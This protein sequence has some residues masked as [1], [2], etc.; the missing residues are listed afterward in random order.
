[1]WPEG[2]ELDEWAEKLDRLGIQ[3][4][5][6]KEPEYTRNAMLTFSDPDN[7]QLG[8]LLGGHPPGDLP[9]RPDAMK[10]RGLRPS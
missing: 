2:L 7:I 5:G 1:M 3:H 8:V 6:V 9:H 10:G 4:S